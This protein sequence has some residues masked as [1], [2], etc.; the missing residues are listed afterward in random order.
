MWMRARANLGLQKGFQS[1][2]LATG[3]QTQGGKKQSTWLPSPS[4]S[5][6]LLTDV[7]DIEDANC[8]RKFP[9]FFELSTQKSGVLFTSAKLRSLSE[10]F[11][12]IDEEFER[13][14]SQLVMEIVSVAGEI[15]KSF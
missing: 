3:Y 11:S 12:V 7:L 9:K 14:Q 13:K 8:L 15:F 4:T 2:L 5:Q 1:P 6:C 10:E